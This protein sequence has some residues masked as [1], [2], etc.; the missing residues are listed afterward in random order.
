[1]QNTPSVIAAAFATIPDPRRSQDKRFPRAGMLTLAVVSILSNHLSLL[2]IA[3]W[4]SSSRARSVP[5]SASRTVSPYI[6]PPCSGCFATSI[7]Y[8]SPPPSAAASPQ[9]LVFNQERW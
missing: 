2:T 4:G 5:R 9:S 3:Q 1:M 8:P 6:R 7:P